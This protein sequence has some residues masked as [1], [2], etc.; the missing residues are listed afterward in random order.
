MDRRTFCLALSSLALPLPTLSAAES[1]ATKPVKLLIPG[2]TGGVT[3]LRGRWL[4]LHLSPILGQPVVVEN[5]A[6]AAGV[7]AMEA[8]AR[9]EPDGHTIIVVHQG[10]MVVNPFMY[11]TLPYDPLR[12][13]TPLTRMGIGAQVLTISPGIQANNV[14]ELV[15]LAKSRRSPLTYGSPGIGTPPHLAVELFK[16]QAGIDA[17]H[18][19][20]KGGGAA[21]SDLL[22]GHIDFQIEG[23]TV[24]VPHIKAGRLRALATTGELR[25]AALP[26]V[27]TMQEAGVRDYVYNGWVGLALPAK[28][29]PALVAR[30]YQ[31]VAQVLQSAES[32]EYF[33]AAGAVPGAVPPD[34]FARSIR[35]EQVKIGRLIREA[36][37]KAE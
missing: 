33:A 35:E 36:G 28:T 37:I 1:W 5:R 4:A 15:A 7:I 24:L 19:P 17:I 2:G 31:S 6:G 27:P 29:P 16:R 21:A 13:F 22:G 3:D 12:D 34:E 9:A 26:D 8:G 14:Q 23:M 10:T 30:V 18:I 25:V 20:Y 11:A 32:V